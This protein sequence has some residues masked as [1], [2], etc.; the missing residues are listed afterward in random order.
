MS[1]E[2]RAKGDFI[3]HEAHGVLALVNLPRS[4]GV[5]TMKTTISQ[6]FRIDGIDVD[7]ECNNTFFFFCLLQQGKWKAQYY[8][9]IYEKDRV[10]PADGQHV[11]TGVF[12]RQELEKYTVGYQYLGT[13]Q[14]AVA[15][16]EIDKKLATFGNG[17]FERMYEAVGK[18]LEGESVDIEKV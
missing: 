2:G 8:K 16:H 15:G 14:M 9:V 13:A 3:L 18:W 1:K 5:G 17:G 7:V 10:L 6:R 12:D 11:P 4:R